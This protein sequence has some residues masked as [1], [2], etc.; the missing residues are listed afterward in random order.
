MPQHGGGERWRCGGRSLCSAA[1][2]VGGEGK[3]GGFSSLREGDF[4]GILCYA[5]RMTYGGDLNGLVGSRSSFSALQH[6]SAVST[7]RREARGPLRC[8]VD[9]PSMWL[10][11]IH[12]SYESYRLIE[13]ADLRK[14]AALILDKCAHEQSELMPG[15]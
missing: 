7:G 14:Q 5:S 13:V 2:G 8:G 6:S 12:P 3:R 10:C 15:E 9:L 1:L 4:L 11:H